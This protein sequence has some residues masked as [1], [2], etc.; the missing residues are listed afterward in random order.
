MKQIN[1][2]FSLDY[3]CSC[4]GDVHPSKIYNVY[5]DTDSET[6]VIQTN[7]DQHQID[8]LVF[9]SDVRVKT[10]SPDKKVRM[11]VSLKSEP[12]QMSLAL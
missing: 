12:E 4:L 2:E 6:V 3:L 8:T 9:G 11:V 7:L 5:L 10:A 1:L